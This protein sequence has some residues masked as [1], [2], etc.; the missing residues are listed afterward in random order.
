MLENV[1]G[2]KGVPEP[3][4]FWLLRLRRHHYES[5]ANAVMGTELASQFINTVYPGY[6]QKELWLN[7]FLLKDIGKLW[8]H[9]EMLDK[10]KMDPGSFWEY[11][12]HHPEYSIR[13]MEHFN[14]SHLINREAVLYHHEYLDGTGYPAGVNW[15]AIGFE[16]RLITV[17][18]SFINKIGNHLDEHNFNIAI[19]ELYMF[20]N[21]LYDEELVLQ[22]TDYLYAV[23]KQLFQSLLVGNKGKC[24]YP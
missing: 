24:L 3:I 21:L 10:S 22:F 13:F 9:S 15:T 19:E 17:I 8:I 23:K 2:E 12:Q 18:D 1:Y 6:D 4:R 5:F 20:S 11:G 14:F 16:A 7:S